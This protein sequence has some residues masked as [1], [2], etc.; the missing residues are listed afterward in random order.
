MIEKESLITVIEAEEIIFSH[1]YKS[2]IETIR[3]EDSLGRH[4][5][6]DWLADDDIPS[7]DRVMMDGIA[8]RFRKEQFG[9]KIIAIQR[10]GEEAGNL[11]SDEDAIEIMTGS[12]LPKGADTVVP[13]EHIVIDGSNANF[14]GP[15]LKLGQNV[16]IRGRDKKQGDLLLKNGR[17]I[18]FTEMGLAASLGLTKILV[19]S[20]PRIAILSTGDELVLPEQKP[21]PHQI[22]MSNVYMLSGLLQQLDMAF[23][24]Q[25]VS[26]DGEALEK[27]IE[28]L[29]NENDVLLLS[30]GVSKGKFDLVP[31]TLMALGVE[32]HLHRIAQKP[33]K[34]FW[35]GTRDDKTVFG[36]PGNP[37]STLVCALRYFRPW[38]YKSF[39]ENTTEQWAI[40][41]YAFTRHKNLTQ[42]IQVK[43]T[44]T[45]E[46]RFSVYPV[47]GGGSGDFTQLSGSDG[48][49][50]IP[51]G[52]GV[53]A[54]GE[55][56][57]F[58][59]FF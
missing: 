30:G 14:Q 11:S 52:V 37:V 55:R 53:I 22:R 59:G 31:A 26:D 12:V 50:E 39:K 21:M 56:L 47:D 13:Y 38:V 18:R 5:A 33:G 6:S 54:D 2:S 3:L 27:A 20:K 32:K 24:F 16:H 25:H 1:L 28:K 58:F 46:D 10:A 8:I 34:P 41:D 43:C 42:F 15:D 51:S 9:W 23:N 4:T 45:S 48:F 36:F 17:Q 29:L 35:F 7:Y 49:V 19:H 40:S 44:Q 57:A